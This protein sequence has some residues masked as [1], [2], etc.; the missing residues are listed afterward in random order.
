MPNA[1]YIEWSSPQFWTQY[2]SIRFTGGIHYAIGL[3]F[4]YERSVEMGNGV[5]IGQRPAL[6]E[7][8][9]NGIGKCYNFA[10]S[11]LEP[12]HGARLRRRHR[13]TYSTLWMRTCNA[14]LDPNGKA[15][16]C[17]SICCQLW[18]RH[19]NSLRL[20]DDGKNRTCHMQS[21]A[22]TLANIM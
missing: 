20:P 4:N 6:D 15:Y 5:E 1:N 21:S 18:R 14:W 11:L 7:M 22:A 17:S 13:K 19:R 3:A 8:P 16:L 9:N 10:T 2:E 12:E